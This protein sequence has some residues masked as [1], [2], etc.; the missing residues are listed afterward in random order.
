M[1]NVTVDSNLMNA[2]GPMYVLLVVIR[3]L[4][5]NFLCI[6]LRFYLKMKNIFCADRYAAS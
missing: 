2:L 1:M 3:C 4:R 6:I 5:L